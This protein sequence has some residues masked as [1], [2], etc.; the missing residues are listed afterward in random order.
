MNTF[1]TA[2]SNFLAKWLGSHWAFAIATVLV[3]V[4]L[5][6]AGLDA[7]NIS[8]SVATLLL[9]LIIQ[10]TQNRDSA[11]LHLKL[12]E[13]ITHLAGARD[14]VAGVESKGEDEI[15]ELRRD[16]N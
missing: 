11:A 9:A 13:V 14:E 8:I 15:E 16:D 6:V 12:D 3:G 10:N 1:F 5:V 4:G 7:T 2:F